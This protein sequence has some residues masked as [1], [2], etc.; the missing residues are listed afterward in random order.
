MSEATYAVIFH[1]EILHGFERDQVIANVAKLFRVKLEQAQRMFDASKVVIKAGLNESAA[2]KYIDVL[3]NAGAK[4]RLELEAAPEPV[5]AAKPKLSVDSAPAA[6]APAMTSAGGEGDANT[7]DTVDSASDAMPNLREVKFQF[8]GQGGEYFKIWIVNLL[9]TI[10]TLGVYSA[11]A[12]VRNKQ[13]FYGNS[14]LD[15]NSFQYTGRPTAILKGRIIGGVFLILYSLSGSFIPVLSVLVTLLLVAF[16]PWIVVRGLK[17]NARNSVYR[18]IRFR[19]NGT[20]RD[21]LFPF[22]AWPVAALVTFGLLSPVAYYKQQRFMVENHAYGSSGFEFHAGW[23]DYVRM[24][25]TLLIGFFGGM[26]IAFVLMGLL[27]PVGLLLMA[28]VYLFAFAY[29][30]VASFNI[31]F[32]NSTLREH[33]FDA[34]MEVKSYA[35]LVLTNTLMMV[36]TL[37]LFRPWAMVR[38]A[39]YKAEHLSLMADGEL[40]KFIAA[41]SEDESALGEEV[42]E[43][44]DIDIGI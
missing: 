24:F 20:T 37:G 27:P 28:S 29:F 11:W 36:V 2:E 31:R 15:G 8:L 39:K 10:L 14:Q 35:L 16:I 18:N 25:V 22:I 30:T 13:Y 4:V 7:G 40:D 1:G 17:F 32:S 9:L 38:V 5:A 43:L 3:T 41:H 42:G 23:R 21:A 44:F 6:A 33:C 19:F 26:V 12:K 34:S